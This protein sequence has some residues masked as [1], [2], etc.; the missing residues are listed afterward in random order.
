[1]SKVIGH[2]K[3]LD[4]FSKI[5]LN[6]KI[7]HAFLFSGEDKIGKKT[8]AFHLA[9]LILCEN[10]ACDK[11]KTCLDIDKRMS[12]DVCL[13]ESENGNIEIDKIRALKE[14][15][16]LKSYSNKK[17]IAIIND[18]HLM[19][20][21]A[22]NS[23]LKLLE[24]PPENSV[25]ILITNFKEMILETIKSRVQSVSFNKVKTEEIEEYLVSEG[26]ENKLAK[27]ISFFAGGKIGKA[28]E[29]L[30]DEGQRDFF[31]ETM[32]YLEGIE[33]QPFDKRFEYVKEIYEDKEATLE[34][35][36]IFERFFRRIMFLKLYG[37]EDVNFKSYSLLKIR[38]I[39]EE[40]QKTKYY[41][42]NTNTNK[43]L[44]LENLMINI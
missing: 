11:C 40:I 38:N 18:A 39:I 31:A 27:E 14:F 43:K 30:E 9:K 5:I 2:K 1:M 34:I 16:L 7:P 33:R 24:E 21:D 29:L 36:N 17:K 28:I 22:Q 44:L 10:N 32:K 42:V 37:K 26:V 4:F 41:F 13:I 6:K 25:L 23:I 8:F 35:L 19:R 20:T 15:L 12:P 3:Q